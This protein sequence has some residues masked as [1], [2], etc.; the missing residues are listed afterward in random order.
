MNDHTFILERHMLNFQCSTHNLVII[1][2]YAACKMHYDDV[3]FVRNSKLIIIIYT[4]WLY[5]NG[6]WV[7]I[8]MVKL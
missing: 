3:L 8:L 5:V 1:K 2:V 7:V 4:K 6:G